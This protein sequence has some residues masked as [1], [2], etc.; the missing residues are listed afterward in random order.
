ML[1]RPALHSYCVQIIFVFFFFCTG[2]KQIQLLEER[3]HRH[4]MEEMMIK[5]KIEQMKKLT[6]NECKKMSSLEQQQ[7]ELT[8]VWQT[9]MNTVLAREHF[10]LTSW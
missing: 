7:N 8:E 6:D 5:L 9:T 1:A 2:E 3:N 4:H 10:N